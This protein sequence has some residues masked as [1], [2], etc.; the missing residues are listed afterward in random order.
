MQLDLFRIRVFPKT[1]HG[2]LFT[3]DLEPA[4]VLRQAMLER[5]RSRLTKRGVDWHVGNVEDLEEGNIYFRLGKQSKATLP[6]IDNTGNFTEAELENSPYTHAVLDVGLELCALAKN[7]A[8][9]PSTIRIARQLQRVLNN[10]ET[11]LENDVR[12]VVGHVKNPDDFLN[13]L[14]K[15]YSIRSFTYTFMRRNPFDEDKDFVKPFGALLEETNGDVGQAT[16]KGTQLRVAPLEQISRSAA[17]TGDDVKARLQLDAESPRVVRKLRGN[18]ASVSVDSLDSPQEK[19]AAIQRA[20][21][22]YRRVRVRDGAA[23]E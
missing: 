10:S 22:E 19:V 8:L 7:T 21:N 23:P 3:Q 20:R 15:A 9:S 16:I 1:A 18:I 14:S 12:F 5:P 6:K 2:S 13:L 11:A 17:T 4:E